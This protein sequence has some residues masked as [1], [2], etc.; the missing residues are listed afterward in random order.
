MEESI[1]HN[2][3]KILLQIYLTWKEKNDMPKFKELLEI[4]KLNEQELKRALKYC[5]EKGFI[6][7]KIIFGLGMTQ[8]QGEFWLK[9]LTSIGI[10]I[11]ESP[12]V[13]SQEK[14][15]FNITLN[16]N[17]EFNVESIIKGEAKLF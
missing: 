8:M 1:S 9:D 13:Q 14:R 16:F 11:I 6:D 15:P 17:N 12:R 10:D 7:L 3:G 5:Y 2:A 4:S